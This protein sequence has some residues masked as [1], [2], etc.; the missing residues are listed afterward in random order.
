MI[1]YSI[2]KNTQVAVKDNG[3]DWG[4]VGQLT[5]PLSNPGR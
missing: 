1:A 4:L 3:L 2:K 5:K